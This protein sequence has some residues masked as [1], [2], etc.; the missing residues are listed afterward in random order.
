MAHNC[1]PRPPAKNPCFLLINSTRKLFYGSVLVYFL[2]GFIVN[3]THV[4]TVRL[5]RVSLRLAGW[6]NMP[7]LVS[8]DFSFKTILCSS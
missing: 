5:S 8:N 7:D 3:K 2:A 4:Q 1:I 6:I